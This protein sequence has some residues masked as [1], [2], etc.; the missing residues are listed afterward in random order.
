MNELLCQKDK[1]IIGLGLQLKETAEFLERDHL[2]AYWGRNEL[3]PRVE[4][5]LLGEELLEAIH[6]RKKR[7]SDSKIKI[8]R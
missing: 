4:K 5:A 1:K 6:V 3:K 8:F 2:T 7:F